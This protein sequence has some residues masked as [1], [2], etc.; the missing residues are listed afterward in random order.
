LGLFAQFSLGVTIGGLALHGQKSENAKYYPL[1]MDR[2]GYAIFFGAISVSA[3]Y[4]IN[5]YFGVKA[6][7]SFIIHDSAGKRA[8]ISHL[9]LELHDDL[10]GMKNPVHQFSHSIGPFWYYRK[11]WSDLDGYQNDPLFITMD[12]DQRWERK[13]VWYG[14]F[15]RYNLKIDSQNDFALD[16]LPGFPFIY[17]LSAGINKNF[18]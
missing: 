6:V 7:H 1:K 3:S 4:R 14:G 2:N 10:F 13:F 15:T 12:A 9:G 18:R 17:A 11:G 8:G 16:F 5:D